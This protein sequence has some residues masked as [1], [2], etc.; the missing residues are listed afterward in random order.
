[1]FS[2]RKAAP[3]A[4]DNVYQTAPFD[5]EDDVPVMQRAES[6][7]AQPSVLPQALSAKTLGEP[8]VM[9]QSEM[10]RQ[11]VNELSNA[12]MRVPAAGADAESARLCIGKKI[13]MKGSVE[14]CGV[15]QVDG[16]FEASAQSTDLIVSES[17][18]FV[19]D[20]DVHNAEIVGQFE[21][22]LIV[23]DKLVIRSTG[24]VR[25]NVTYGSIAIDSGG[26][27][28]GDIQAMLKDKPPVEA[29]APK[30]AVPVKQEPSQERKPLRLNLSDV[31]PDPADTV[32]S[33][34]KAVEE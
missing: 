15:L 25:G 24:V 33:A 10:A 31:P 14:D 8:D 3:P 26:S 12:R 22:N 27:L 9:A 29:T 30:E 5:E 34:P 20:A 13:K 21:G 16:H 7:Q 6:P 32:D 17:G 19:G 4:F 18:V 23:K 1:M 11:Y 28:S 2:S